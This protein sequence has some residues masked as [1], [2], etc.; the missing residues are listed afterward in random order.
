M[1]FG[2]VQA[3]GI[4]SSDIVGYSTQGI[5]GGKLY[6]VGLQFGSVGQDGFARIDQVL[7]T[8]GISAVGF[9]G[10]ETAAAEIMF[11]NGTGYD[12][13]Y[14]INEAYD[15]ATDE[16]VDGNYWVDAS[17]YTLTDEELKTLGTGLWL[18]IPA[19]VCAGEATLTSAGRVDDDDSIAIMLFGSKGGTLNLASNPYPTAT[20]LSKISVEGLVA[21]GFDGMESSANEIM[22][23]NGIGYDHYYYINE[24]YDSSTDEPIDGDYWVD[25]SGYAVT[26]PVASVGASFWAK[27]FQ[28]GSLTFTK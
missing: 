13:F 15:P 26:S 7:S 19:G 12:H 21:A 24:A 22:F 17:G 6:N 2:A 10:M 18:K 4:V 9:D 25:A 3:D 16:P 23:W 27:I 28:N 8:S 1:D 20:D 11:W 14:Y 5:Q